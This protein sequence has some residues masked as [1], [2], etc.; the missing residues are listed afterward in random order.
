MFELHVTQTIN[1][2][3]PVTAKDLP[4][5]LNP[6]DPQAIADYFSD[7]EDALTQL[8]DPGAHFHSVEDR[9]VGGIEHTAPAAEPQLGA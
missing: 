8:L 3:V 2:R 7:N 6:A 1:Y 5:H 9:A 4:E